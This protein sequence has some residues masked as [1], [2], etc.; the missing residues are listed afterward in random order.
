MRLSTGLLSSLSA[1]LAFAHDGGTQKAKNAPRQ[2]KV[3]Y[4]V[5]EPPLTTPWTYEVGTNPWTEYPRPQLQ[6]PEWKNLNGIWTY[7]RAQS[8]QAVDDPPFG[9]DLPNE[10]MIPSCLESGL[11]GKFLARWYINSEHY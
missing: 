4:S 7:E 11:S 5:K 10:V 9:V 8:L 2:Q 3:E 1:T 6:R